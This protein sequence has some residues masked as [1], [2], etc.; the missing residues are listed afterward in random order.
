MSNWLA[1]VISDLIGDRG[2]ARS[3]FLSTIMSPFKI[4]LVRYGNPNLYGAY[5]APTTILFLLEGEVQGFAKSAFLIYL[6]AFYFLKLQV[7][8]YSSFVFGGFQEVYLQLS[9]SFSLNAFLTHSIIFVSH[10][11]KKG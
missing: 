11:C 5:D 6:K 10:D 7:Y 8:V 3:S 4:E 9:F 1:R 2:V